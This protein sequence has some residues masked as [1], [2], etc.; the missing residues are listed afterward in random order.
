M[1]AITNRDG[2]IARLVRTS[3]CRIAIEPG[4]DAALADAIVKLKNDVDGCASIGQRAR[5]MLDRAF[6]REHA[7][8]R[9]R[10]VIDTI[11]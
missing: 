6:N 2:E 8:E 10:S 1:I 5:L 7:L 11:H 3:G 4:D 9:W